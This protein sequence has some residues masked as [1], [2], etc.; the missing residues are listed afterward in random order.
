MNTLTFLLS[1]INIK[2]TETP[3][4]VSAPKVAESGSVS[5]LAQGPSLCERISEAY[6][7]AIRKLVEFLDK[8][9][10]HATAMVIGTVLQE[11]WES[12]KAGFLCLANWKSHFNFYN[13]NPTTLTEEQ[14]K[15][16]P[17]LLIHGNYHNQSGWLSLAKHLEASKLGPVFTANTLHGDISDADYDIIQRKIDEIKAQYHQHNIRN[18]KIN[19]VGH[20]R[21]GCIAHQMA[22]TTLMEDGKRYWTRSEDIGKV[23]KIGSILAQ[24]EIVSIEKCDP[25][26]RE[27]VYEITGKYDILSN[28]QSSLP[29]NRKVTVPSGHLGLLSSPETP[30]HVIQWLS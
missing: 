12:I 2:A 16:Q 8:H 22:W 1:L 3:A 11:P 26:F 4:P 17:I 19:V 23:I 14:L 15:K 9:Q 6:N 24:E 21:G 29:A 25:N 28:A 18:V 27:R 20:S 7:N 13:M 5:G 10:W 30:Q